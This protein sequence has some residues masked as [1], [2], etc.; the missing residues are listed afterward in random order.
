MLGTLGN[1]SDF[2]ENLAESAAVR[3][4]ALTARLEL[5]AQGVVSNEIIWE[6]K[7]R[8]LM[9]LIRKISQEND[10][11]HKNFV[12]LTIKFNNSIR[13]IF[14]APLHQLKVLDVASPR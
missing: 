10:F 3:R 1:G 11:Y 2:E 5:V 7:V 8:S 9:K 12:S 14:F 13:K 6:N 4:R